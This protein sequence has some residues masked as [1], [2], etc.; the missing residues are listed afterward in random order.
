M[1]SI[2]RGEIKGNTYIKYVS[3]SKAV[4]WRDRMISIHKDVIENWLTDSIKFIVFIDRYKGEIWKAKVERVKESMIL[5]QVGQ[6]PQYYIP[7]EVF[8]TKKVLKEI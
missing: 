3:F 1:K 6:E 5:K 7:I 2:N 4:L 8:Q